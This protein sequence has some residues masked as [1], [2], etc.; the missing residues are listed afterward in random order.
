MTAP[1]QL[2]VSEDLTWRVGAVVSGK[3]DDLTAR[4]GDFVRAG[5]IIGRIHSHD[6]HEARAAYQQAS[7]ELE[8]AR[9]A[10]AYSERLRDRAQ[11]LFELKAGSRQDVETAEAGAAKRAGR[12]RESTKRDR[13]GTRPSDG[14]PPCGGR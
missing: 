2:T 3:V 13:Q 14:H 12:H 10:E 6:V 1:G 11:R 5:Q 4:V 7:T 8:R 9:A